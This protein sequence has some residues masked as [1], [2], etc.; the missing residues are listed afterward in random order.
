MTSAATL[1]CHLLNHVE[2]RARAS[3]VRAAARPDAHAHRYMLSSLLY[4]MFVLFKQALTCFPKCPRLS[5]FAGVPLPAPCS[6]L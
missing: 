6:S 3:A 5:W 1:A 2:I 4:S